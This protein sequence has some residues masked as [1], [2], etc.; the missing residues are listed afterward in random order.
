MKRI[1]GRSRRTRGRPDAGRLMGIDHASRSA[2]SRAPGR[3]PE[4]PLTARVTVGAPAGAPTRVR[5]GA[6]AE[7]S[8]RPRIGRR[9][10][11]YSLIFRGEGAVM[12]VDAELLEIL[13]CPKC[14][15]PV[16]P[17]RDGAGLKCGTCRRVYPIVDDIPVMLI[18]EA[19]IEEPPEPR[20]PH[21]LEEPPATAE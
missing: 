17:V 19:T 2:R 8:A 20:R 12:A 1:S 7:R 5:P 13:A 3:G 18:D 16:T 6:G 9:G 4:H 10:L 21:A 14:K 15:T 11:L